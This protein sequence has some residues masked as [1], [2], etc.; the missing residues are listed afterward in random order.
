LNRRPALQDIEKAIV[1]PVHRQRQAVI[2]ENRLPKI[3]P[4]AL[5]NNNGK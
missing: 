5:A 4:R 2:A 3:V 1:P